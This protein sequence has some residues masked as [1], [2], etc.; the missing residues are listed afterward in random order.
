MQLFNFK[1]EFDIRT[2]EKICNSCLEK[3]SEAKK[4]KSLFKRSEKYLLDLSQAPDPIETEPD[5]FWST[6]LKDDY[7][8]EDVKPKDKQIKSEYAYEFRRRRS[9]VKH[10]ELG[11]HEKQE[12]ESDFESDDKEVDKDY[13]VGSDTASETNDR[14]VAKEFPCGVCPK[15]FNT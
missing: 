1:I 3:F 13:D 7:D 12:E 15:S 11:F 6:T 10:V 8:D 2:P 14:F 9:N 5:D 4:I